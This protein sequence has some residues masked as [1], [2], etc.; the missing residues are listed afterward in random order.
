MSRKSGTFFGYVCIYCYVVCSEGGI[1][2]RESTNPYED[3][4]DLI[5]DPDAGGPSQR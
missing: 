3:L 2:M 4:E 5:F 1:P